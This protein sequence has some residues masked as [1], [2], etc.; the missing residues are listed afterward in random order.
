MTKTLPLGGMKRFMPAQVEG[1]AGVMERASGGKSKPKLYRVSASSE[2]EVE[3]GFM[4]FRWREKLDHS[5][6]AVQL[7]RFASGRAPVLVDHETGDQVGVIQSAELK[8][9]R[10]VTEV[11]F[12]RSQRAQEIQQD[13]DDEIRGPSSIGYLPKRARLVEEDEENGDLWLITLWEPVELSLVPVPADPTVGANRAAGITGGFPPVEIEE[14]EG[15]EV[16][17]T[18]GAP[19]R[20]RE[21]ELV[22]ISGMCQEYGV[23]L[24]REWIE[25]GLTPDA[26]GREILKLQA[27]GQVSLGAAPAA[28][29]PLDALSLR[30]RSRFSYARAILV[31]CGEERGGVEAEVS[32]G[33]ARAYP[34]ARRGSSNS[35]MVPLR[36][37]ASKRGALD[38]KTP[39]GSSELVF[40]Q[41]GEL[42]ELL[43]PKSLCARAGARIVSGLTGNV[44]FV[45]KTGA[46]SV[47]WQSENPGPPGVPQNNLST[48]LVVASP[49]TLMGF[50]SYSRQLLIQA[51]S[52]GL[53]AEVM[54]REDLAEGH[55]LAFDGAALHGSGVGGEPLGVFAVPG[56]NAGTLSDPPSYEELVEMI[57]LVGDAN[58]ETDRLQ[59]FM[60][61]LL[62]AKLK[63]VLV[64]SAAGS[65]MIWEGPLSGGMVAGYKAWASNQVSKVLGAGGNEHGVALGDWS[66][67]LFLTWNALELIVDPFT[68]KT[69]GLVEIV[70][71]QLGDTLVRQP[72]AFA[73]A[74]AGL[75]A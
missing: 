24:R 26:V 9:R 31:A 7:G 53:D 36:I 42:I 34:G 66:Q 21:A 30:D 49:K 41:P 47:T 33:L 32:Q 2:Y 73:V 59:W 65:A 56:T 11:R 57:G 58:A 40:D 20:N 51:A 69:E 45:K 62:A 18:N 19:T 15:I 64:A 52:A 25:R 67:V 70:S 75:G 22:E 60:T 1:T 39:G 43:R 50:E 44:G 71:Y 4:G 72:S 6:S 63:A 8:A 13:V 3:R 27:A 61:P 28:E 38:T 74:S 68:K 14:M 29:D 48:G 17:N 10:V 55:A 5:P 37:G 12:G 54:V 23:T 16:G 46:G 35:I